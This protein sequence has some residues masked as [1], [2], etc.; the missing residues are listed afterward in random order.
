[1]TMCRILNG[2]NADCRAIS[3]EILINY[4]DLSLSAQHFKLTQVGTCLEWCSQIYRPTSCWVSRISN[5]AEVKAWRRMDHPLSSHDHPADNKSS[6]AERHL[7]FSATKPL[8]GRKARSFDSTRWSWCSWT[9]LEQNLCAGIN[10]GHL[11]GQE[12]QWK[13]SCLA[14]CNRKRLRLVFNVVSSMNFWESRT[15]IYPIYAF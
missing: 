10:T 2:F 3:R 12:Q 5:T 15:P 4:S 13:A 1:M 9:Y 14:P 6:I 8:C 11:W 7:E